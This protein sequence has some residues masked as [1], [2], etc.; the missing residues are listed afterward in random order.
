MNTITVTYLIRKPGNVIETLIR[1]EEITLTR[2]GKE[3][4]KIV[5]IKKKEKDEN[6]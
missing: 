4:A 6:H 5:P 1:G 2:N 3:L